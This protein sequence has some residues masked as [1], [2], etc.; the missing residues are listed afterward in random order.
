MKEE[1]HFLNSKCDVRLYAHSQSVQVRRASKQLQ[2]QQKMKPKC[3]GLTVSESA[4]FGS[5]QSNPTALG[6]IVTLQITFC[7]RL[8]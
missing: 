2:V 4:E 5:D 7:Y 8:L 1:S 3:A 6:K